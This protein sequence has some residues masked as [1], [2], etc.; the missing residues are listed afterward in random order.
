VNR[1]VVTTTDAL[2]RGAILE[3]SLDRL[4]A[5]T[6]TRVPL[7]LADMPGMDHDTDHAGMVHASS[8]GT[9]TWS[10]DA[11]VLP[12]ASQWDTTVRVLGSATEAEISRQRFAFTMSESG[13]DEGRA[14][15]L[16]DPAVGV[17]LLLGLGGA[18]GIG[19]GIGGMRLPRCEAVASRVALLGGGAT[20]VVLGGAI[21]VERVLGL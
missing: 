18:L 19:L 14:R 1:I 20:A 3:L 12:A 4:D 2:A 8:D 13:I 15:T 5:G 7:T 6:S 10:A 11:L 9:A 21:G 17:A 16:V